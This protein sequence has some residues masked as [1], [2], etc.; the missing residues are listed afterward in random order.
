MCMCLRAET[1]KKIPR[2]FVQTSEF[3]W[4]RKVSVYGKVFTA[5]G[6]VFTAYGK[7][8]TASTYA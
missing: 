2:Q 5:Y 7:V 8:F 3:T 6:K 1:K 4:N